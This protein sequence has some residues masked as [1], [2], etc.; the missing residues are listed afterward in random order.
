MIHRFFVTICILSVASLSACQATAS[1]PTRFTILSPQPTVTYPPTVHPTKPTATKRPI[2]SAE[3]EPT[4]SPSA[5]QSPEQEIDS[6]DIESL[7]SRLSQAWKD[8]VSAEKVRTQLENDKWIISPDYDWMPTSPGE[9]FVV[10]DLN[11]DGR[12]EWIVSVFMRAGSCFLG[13]PSKPRENG[14]LWIIG[15]GG[16]IY[17]L[18]P[19]DSDDF[20]WGAP[21][22]ISTHD[23]TGD[24]LP[25]IVT[26]SV[27]CG[28]H[29]ALGGYHVLSFRTGK[30]DSLVEVEN[31]LEKA[32]NFVRAYSTPN[33]YGWSAKEIVVPTPSDKIT[34]VTNDGLPDLVLMGGTYGSAGA[35]YVRLRTE[36]W[37]WTGS[38]IVLTSISWEQTNERFHL[39]YDA[40]FAFALENYSLARSQYERVIMDESLGNDVGFGLPE[41][42]LAAAQ[43]FAGFRLVLL[44]LRESDKPNALKWN[45][46][47][48][49]KY[50]GGLI[51]A[52]ADMLIE[53]WTDLS[54]ER[55]VCEQI[56]SFLQEQSAE[57][58]AT[59]TLSDAG[60]GNPS[61]NATDVC[62][63]P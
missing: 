29:T 31:E 11:G 14:E 15:E 16:L 44:S 54:H 53:K 4:R 46:W 38:N 10:A 25:E 27:G 34:D 47:L 62:P 60:Y 61:L 52:A 28:A 2:N 41:E 7:V 49:S 42:N 12:D 57:N 37:S 55:E 8:D 58:P 51:S 33:I 35:G 19:T 50:E 24:D 9:T 40:N 3:V 18:Y 23:V 20:F 21:L 56:A 5:T 45:N 26:R 1:E 63:L 32:A 22:I 48:H 30:I 43:Q 13:S 36:V 59:G 17:R 6:Q 39:L